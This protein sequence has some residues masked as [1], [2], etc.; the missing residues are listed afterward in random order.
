[1][2]SKAT[3]LEELYTRLLRL[4]VLSGPGY[5]IETKQFTSTRD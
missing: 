2:K 4:N 3:N 5:V 1:M